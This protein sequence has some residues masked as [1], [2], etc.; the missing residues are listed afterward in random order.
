MPPPTLGRIRRD[1]EG[2]E[3]WWEKGRKRGGKMGGKMWGLL[4][5]D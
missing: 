2:G 4:L 1:M 3:G 5:C